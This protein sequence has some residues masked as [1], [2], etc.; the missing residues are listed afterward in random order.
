MDTIWRGGYFHLGRN[1][2]K[3]KSAPEDRGGQ[4]V[5]KP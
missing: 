1:F 2:F 5:E 4:S 3:K